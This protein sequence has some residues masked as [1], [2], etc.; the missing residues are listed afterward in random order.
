MTRISDQA[1]GFVL[2][3]QRDSQN[4]WTIHCTGSIPSITF[5]LQPATFVVRLYRAN[6][7]NYVRGTI[8]LPAA[9]LSTPINCNDSIL[10]LIRAWLRDIT[11]PEPTV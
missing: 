2:Q 6:T 1:I 8:E 10:V 7:G 5:A 11:D 9:N 4:A 3:I